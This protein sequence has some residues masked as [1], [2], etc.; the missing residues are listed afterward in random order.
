MLLLCP[1][2]QGEAPEKLAGRQDSRGEG[3]GEILPREWQQHWYVEILEL[4]SGAGSTP[5]VVG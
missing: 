3:R 1:Q 4:Q 2:P 5:Q